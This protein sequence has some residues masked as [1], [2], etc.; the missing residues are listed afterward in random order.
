MTVMSN[1]FIETTDSYSSAEL[2]AAKNAFL[3][4]EEVQQVHL[5][6]VMPTE[7]AV[8]ILSQCSVHYAQRLIQQLK[9]EGHEKQAGHYARQLGFIRSETATAKRELLTRVTRHIKQRAGWVIVLALFGLGL[10]FT[11]VNY[12]LGLS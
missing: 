5:L 8:G 1:I 12:F 2:G 3:Q 11:V 9:A 10:Y 6:T 7:E 4:Y